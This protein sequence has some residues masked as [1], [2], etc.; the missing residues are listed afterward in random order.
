MA[1]LLTLTLGGYRCAG[2]S[3]LLPGPGERAETEPAPLGLGDSKTP[4]PPSPSSDVTVLTPPA[5]CFYD[6]HSARCEMPEPEPEPDAEPE[7]PPWSVSHPAFRSPQPGPGCRPG[8]E[9]FYQAQVERLAAFRQVEALRAGEDGDAQQDQPEDRAGT[10]EARAVALSFWSNVVLF[11]AKIVASLMSGSMVV[12]VSTLDS[13][14]DLLSGGILLFTARVAR[15]PDAA[16]Y[17]LGKGRAEPLGIIV[18]ERT[19]IHA[20]CCRSLFALQLLSLAVPLRR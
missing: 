13:A 10:A 20:C 16:T 6:R 15:R 8:C 14:L 2:W 5:S 19:S 3:T 7:P 18:C 12:L 1:W 4:Q 11:A 17:P 9:G